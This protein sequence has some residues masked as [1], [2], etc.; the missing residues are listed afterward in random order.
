[1]K[2]AD[3]IKDYK[4]KINEA[5]QSI[6]NKKLKITKNPFLIDYYSEMKDYFLTGG[7]RIR[8]LLC[9]ATY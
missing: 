8:P 9:L 3:Y 5:I 4:N 6:Y 2:L 7:K 1:M